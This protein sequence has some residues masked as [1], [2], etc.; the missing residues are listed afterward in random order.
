MDRSKVLTVFS[1]RRVQFILKHN[2]KKKEGE[3]VV[4]ET[5]LLQTNAMKSRVIPVGLYEVSAEVLLQTNT[6]GEKV[7]HKR[8]KGIMY[9]YIREGDG[10][11]GG[12]GQRLPHN[13]TGITLPWEGIHRDCHR[14]N[15]PQ[16][17]CHCIFPVNKVAVAEAVHPDVRP[18]Y[19]WL[20]RADLAIVRVA[21]VLAARSL[22]FERVL[23]VRDEACH[24]YESS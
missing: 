23:T 13:P 19:H 16:R 22:A 8:I 6:M 24:G 17:R 12:G 11:E 10:G 1:K 7:I 15:P 18:V 2:T 21:L 9:V 14:A 20:G 4:R 5:A 3:A